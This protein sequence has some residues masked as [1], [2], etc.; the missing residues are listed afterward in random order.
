MRSRLNGWLFALFCALLLA[1]QIQAATDPTHGLRFMTEDYPPFN[2]VDHGRLTGIS[3][4]LLEQIFAK[5]GSTKT[6]EDVMVHPW[7]RGYHTIMTVPNTVLFVMTR[8]PKREGLV[9][10]VGPVAASPI[11]LLARKDRHLK[12]NSLAD[13]AEYSVVAIKSDIADLVLDDHN[14][15]AKNR[16]VV[17][18][19]D[20]AAR[21]LNSRRIDMWSYGHLAALW[22]LKQEGAKTDEFEVVWDFG[23]A[24]DN[25]Y[26]FHK[27]TPD[28][29]INAFQKA[30]DSLKTDDNGDGISTY[31]TILNKYMR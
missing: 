11:V 28:A 6:R 26:A 15:P 14:I 24:G 19:P 5:L 27:D 9:R 8:N 22:L 4:D 20:I 23:S 17:P 30:L 3:V 1:P 2:Y 18:Y 10:W 13:V 25:Y 29:V 16:Q 12:V 31:Q 7:A 21:M